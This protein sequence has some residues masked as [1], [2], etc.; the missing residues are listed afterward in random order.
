MKPKTY[1]F[2]VS[3]A[4]IKDDHTWEERHVIEACFT[5]SPTAAMA[6]AELDV[7]RDCLVQSKRL[8][9]DG[10]PIRQFKKGVLAIKPLTAK[11]INP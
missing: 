4:I 1:S 6:A 8:D 2:D 5:A 10:E 9:R 3:V 7:F 11:R